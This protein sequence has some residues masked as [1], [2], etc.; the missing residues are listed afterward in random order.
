MSKLSLGGYAKTVSTAP[1]PIAGWPGYK[2]AKRSQTL[3]IPCETD[4]K[5]N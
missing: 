1:P 4:E 2:G 5:H 3:N